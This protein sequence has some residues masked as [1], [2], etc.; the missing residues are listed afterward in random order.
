MAR[1]PFEPNEQN[2]EQV[3]TLAS[4]AVR[5]DDI[6]TVLRISTKTLRKH[7]R[8]ELDCS[9]IEANAR[10]GEAL[11]QMAASGKNAA[12]SIFWAKVRSGWN[13]RPAKREPVQ[14]LPPFNLIFPPPEKAR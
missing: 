11:L 4:L 9:A 6:A 13:E 3:R 14:G 7:F 10:V 2:R 12:A 8:V 5:H 1:A